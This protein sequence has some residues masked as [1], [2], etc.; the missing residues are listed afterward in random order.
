[1]SSLVVS[2]KNGQSLDSFHALRI[3]K[4]AVVHV[5]RRRAL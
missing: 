4:S 1:M 5:S 2:D 3:E